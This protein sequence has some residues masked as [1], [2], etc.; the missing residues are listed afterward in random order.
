MTQDDEERAAVERVQEYLDDQKYFPGHD[1]YRFISD[2]SITFHNDLRL[3]LDRA[4]RA[5]D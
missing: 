3:L 2:H 5:H 4:T 1:L